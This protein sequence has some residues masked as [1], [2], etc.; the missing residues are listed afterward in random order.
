LVQREIDGRKVILPIWHN[1]TR[2]DV[3][4]YSV[5]LADK[6]AGT[7]GKGIPALAGEL[8]AAIRD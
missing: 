1:V 8:Y 4:R 5:T 6:F 3:M 2:D 7:T